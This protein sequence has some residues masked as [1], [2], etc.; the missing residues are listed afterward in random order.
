MELLAAVAGQSALAIE[1]AQ[2]H[3]QI[4]EQTLLD[5]DLKLAKQV[6]LAFLPRKAPTSVVTSFTSSTRQPIGLAVITLTSYQSIHI[7]GLS[8]SLTWLDTAWR[9]LC[10]MA[11]LSAETRF[12]FS[13]YS[14]PAIAMKKLND[15]LCEL[16]AE[17][18]V[19][20][21]L[22]IVDSE[23]NKIT[24]ANAGHMSRCLGHQLARS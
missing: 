1:N 14:D 16:N 9:L 5:Q 12:A 3:E 21:I 8:W 11:K 13:A 6:Q 17:R 24:V 19:T 15:S 20:M 10:F 22:V 7:V 23:S 4:V 18:F 2:L